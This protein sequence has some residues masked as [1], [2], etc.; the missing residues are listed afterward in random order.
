MLRRLHTHTIP[1]GTVTSVHIFYTGPTNTTEQTNGMLLFTGSTYQLIAKDQSGNTLSGASGTWASTDATNFPVNSTGLISPASGI[2]GGSI[3]F[4]HTASGQVGTVLISV[5]KTPGAV[6]FQDWGYNYAN[7]A[8]LMANIASATT[9]VDSTYNSGLPVPTGT[10]GVALYADGTNV[11]HASIDSTTSSRQF[12]G[13]ASI[14]NTL[15]TTSGAPAILRT[16]LPGTFI[17]T[18]VL[19]VHK[20]DAPFTLQGTGGSG[21]QAYKIPAWIILDNNGGRANFLTTNGNDTA[22]QIATDCVIRN[23]SGQ[24]GGGTEVT[25]GTLTTELTNAETWVEILLYEGR[26]SNIPSTRVGHFKIGSVPSLTYGV[27]NEGPMV[28]NPP[29]AAVPG[30]QEISIIGEN[31][32]QVPPIHNDYH[33]VFGNMLVNGDTYGDP[34]G[35]LADISSPTLTGIS[36]GTITQGDL[37]DTITLT[38]TNFNANC[39]PVFSNAKI[40]AQSITVNSST[41]ITVVVSVDST[42]TTGAGTVKIYN[43]SSQINSATQVVTVNA[44]G[45]KAIRQLSAFSATGVPTLTAT[46]T[47]STIVVGIAMVGGET[48]TGVTDN[49]GNSYTACRTGGTAYISNT[50]GA[51]AALDYWICKNATA[52]VTTVT[53]AGSS[54]TPG[55]Y[56]AECLGLS[57]TAP[58][59]TC[60][61][62]YSATSST[63]ITGAAVTTTTASQIIFGSGVNPGAY[64]AISSVASPFTLGPNYT[65][66]LI[67]G[68]HYIASST[69]TYTP[70][71]TVGTAGTQMGSTITLT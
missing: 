41:Q 32:N 62:V 58:L 45:S 12:M 43:A 4:T 27:V 70:T 5:L 66:N 51:G 8:A 69:G 25:M 18:W 29:A 63:T 40:Y 49:I 14:V 44:S 1:G 71:F 68:A 26:S 2:G 10:Y 21:A 42:A 52:G 11:N 54:S 37:T 53:V 15:T 36:G 3:T 17:R 48:V 22:G 39:W 30:P 60:N 6:Y 31:F 59:Q 20:F 7:T 55:A 16:G 67:C 57:A 65:G 50:S 35:V 34:F 47:G 46:L 9:T 23:G 56:A 64:N 24:I 28:G 13:G 38:G 33:V 19:S 61:S